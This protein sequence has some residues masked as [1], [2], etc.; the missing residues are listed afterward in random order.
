LARS[1]GLRRSTTAFALEGASHHGDVL[2]AEAL[3]YDLLPLASKG[4]E[5]GKMPPTYLLEG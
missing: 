4:S 1:A 3:F 5:N 2:I